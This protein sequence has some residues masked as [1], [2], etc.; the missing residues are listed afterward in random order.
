MSHSKQ[1]THCP[2]C[3][4][5]LKQDPEDSSKLVCGICE[6]TYTNVAGKAS[7]VLGEMKK[8]RE[9]ELG[10]WKIVNSNERVSKGKLFLSYIGL[11]VE[12][13]GYETHVFPFITVAFCVLCLVVWLLLPET[14]MDKWAFWSNDPSKNWGLNWVT[15]SFF[16][17]DFFHLAGNLFFLWP[18]MDNVEEHLGHIR[19]V[20]FIVISAA[21][22][23]LFQFIF[24]PV[25]DLPMVGASGVCFGF[26]V[27]Y[28]LKY[29][30]R[31]LLVGVPVFGFL[32]PT[33][34]L[35]L[36]ATSLLLFLGFI[37]FSGLLDQ[38]R[39]VTLT[40][41]LGHIGGAVA[42]ILAWLVWRNVDLLGEQA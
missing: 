40:S 17:A 19:T 34:R 42:G 20:I 2:H 32:L 13:E 1:L 30:K 36:R 11:P 39:M 27:L 6:S 9:A 38:L 5:R 31:R 14:L 41:H 29:P 3:E 4:V 26:A 7:Q 18:F 33:T 24:M 28:C 22:S 15:Y 25:E 8:A 23:V 37:E 10:D 12:E 16:H 35:R 21:C